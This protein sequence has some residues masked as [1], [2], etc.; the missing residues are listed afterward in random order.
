MPMEQIKQINSQNNN[1]MSGNIPQRGISNA[2]YNQ[3]IQPNPID[4]NTIK[5]RDITQNMPQNFNDSA[6]IMP[7]NIPSNNSN[8]N[9]PIMQNKQPP[10]NTIPPNM[11]GNFQNN[12][13]NI[14]QNMQSSQSPAQ[15]TPMV[16]TQKIP[17]AYMHNNP[18]YYERNNQSFQSNNLYQ[19]QNTEEIPPSYMNQMNNNYMGNPNMQGGQSYMRQQQPPQNQ[20][21]SMQNISST[22]QNPNFYPPQ[23]PNNYNQ[24]NP[25]YSMG[26]GYNTNAQNNNGNKMMNIPSQM[27]NMSLDEKKLLYEKIKNMNKRPNE[28][29]HPQQQT[30]IIIFIDMFR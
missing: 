13:Q 5:P 21:Y 7:K 19:N 16:Q 27:S 11:Q 10:M 2:Q 3:P 17:P 6:N 22:N 23:V 25:N 18:N 29:A 9:I 26:S 15:M 1:H 28:I 14:P 12:P 30:S 24:M 4:Y 8:T 20:S